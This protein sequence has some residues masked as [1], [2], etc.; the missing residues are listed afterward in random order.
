VGVR[1]EVEVISR[2]AEIGR[3]LGPRLAHGEN[4]AAER[5][6]ALAVDLSPWDQGTLAGAHMVEPAI[7]PDEGAAVV[8]DTPYAA[9]LHEHPEYNFSTDAN[10][11]AQ[12]KWVETAIIGHADELGAIIVKAVN[13][14]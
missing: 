1:V 2:F 9:R 7:D 6:A 14:G 12:G 11:N 13:D 8:V 10:P 5:G 3:S 4:L